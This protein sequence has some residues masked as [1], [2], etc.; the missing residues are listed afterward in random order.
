MLRTGLNG[1]EITSQQAIR[2]NLNPIC[3]F[4]SLV[5]SYLHFIIQCPVFY[6]SVFLT[7]DHL[8]L[9]CVFHIFNLICV[10]FLPF[11][12]ILMMAVQSMMLRSAHSSTPMLCCLH[13]QFPVLRSHVTVPTSP[14]TKSLA[15]KG[16]CSSTV[17]WTQLLGRPSRASKSCSRMCLSELAKFRSD[18][19]G[20]IDLSCCSCQMTKTWSRWDNRRR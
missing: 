3:I 4:K 20:G 16:K 9:P 7:I 5:I 14:C 18:T 2:R 15:R 10:C 1:I 17:W 13:P 11:A 19:K 6:P 8:T 12:E